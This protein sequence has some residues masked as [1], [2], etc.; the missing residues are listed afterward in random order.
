MPSPLIFVVRFVGFS[1]FFLLFPFPNLGGEEESALIQLSIPPMKKSFLA[2]VLATGLTSFA[3]NA[4]AQI[5]SSSQDLSMFGYLNQLEPEITN[6]FG[7]NGCVPT[8][9][10]NAMVYLQ[11]IAPGTFGNRLAGSTYNDWIETDLQLGSNYLGTTPTG[12]TPN[13]GIQSGLQNYFNDLGFTNVQVNAQLFVNTTNSSGNALSSFPT[14]QFFQSALSGSYPIIFGF[15]AAALGHEGVATGL[16]WDPMSGSGTL[17]FIDP[18]YASLGNARTGPAVATTASISLVSTN[19]P[20]LDGSGFTTS[21]TDALY[22]T[23]NSS[24]YGSNSGY[25]SSAVLFMD[26]SGGYGAIPEPS[27]YALFGIGAIGML[28]VMRRKKT[29]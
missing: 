17:D 10:V 16:T 20:F 27:T 9:S 24:L 21:I 14:I 4:K 22:I 28:M 8:S 26:N 2:F 15:A 23:Y 6:S 5:F 12:A 18:M 3:G 7:N 13:N 19:L 1:H 29:A 25:I 11:N